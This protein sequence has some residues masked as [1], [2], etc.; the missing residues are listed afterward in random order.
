MEVFMYQNFEKKLSIK[1]SQLVMSFVAFG[2][3]GMGN[4]VFGNE[5]GHDH[6]HSK[7]NHSSM[8][9]SKM[10]HSNMKKGSRKS[11]TEAAQKSVV[12]ALEANEALHGSFFKYD[13]KS[14]EANAKKL[15]KAIDAIEDKEIAKLLNFSK[16]KLLEIKASNKRELNDKNYHLV[17]MALIHIV[18]KYDVGSKY[19][20]YSCPMV[21]KKWIQNSNKMAKVHNPYAPEMPHCGS[22]DSHY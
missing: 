16:G 11:L 12:S 1:K 20:A 2:L 7:M 15:K 13:A 8:N 5:G 9:H 4:P 6:D 22:Q 17:S 3:L 18:N 19:N 14:V 10:G 21:K